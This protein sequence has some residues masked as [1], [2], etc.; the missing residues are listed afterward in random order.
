ME[1]C[2]IAL[3]KV[4]W[5]IDRKGALFLREDGDD[6]ASSMTQSQSACLSKW[7]DDKRIV[8]V[9]IGSEYHPG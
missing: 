2:G 3:D 6:D 5:H 4:N 8:M 1:R 9:I 7:A